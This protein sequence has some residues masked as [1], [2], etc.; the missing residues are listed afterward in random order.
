MENLLEK[1]WDKKIFEHTSKKKPLLGIC[2]GMQLLFDLGRGRWR[3]QGIRID[4]RKS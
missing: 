2:L 1:G 3:M 4:C